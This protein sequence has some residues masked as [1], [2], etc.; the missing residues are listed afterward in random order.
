[1]IKL[2]PNSLLVC[3]VHDRVA[4]LI[5]LV[6]IFV[7]C[8]SSS[9]QPV[10]GPQ[11]SARSPRSSRVPCHSRPLSNTLYCPL[12]MLDAP[13]L[14]QSRDQDTAY[15][16]CCPVRPFDNQDMISSQVSPRFYFCQALSTS[17]LLLHSILSTSYQ[18]N[19]LFPF[20]CH[21]FPILSITPLLS[22]SFALD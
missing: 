5:T 4:E 15:L 8:V 17:L 11:V 6:P 19:S 9:I 13:F 10:S 12:P 7:L 22:L 21:C 2:S 18:L 3:Y 20:Y 14:V 16:M 1:M